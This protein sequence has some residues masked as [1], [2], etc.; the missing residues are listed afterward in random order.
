MGVVSWIMPLFVACSTFGALN[1]AIFASARLFFVGARN[2]HLPTSISLINIYNFTP[3]PSL[4]FLVRFCKNFIVLILNNFLNK[5]GYNIVHSLERKNLLNTCT[6]F[7]YHLIYYWIFNS[8]LTRLYINMFKCSFY[9]RFQTMI[10]YIYPWNFC[11][12]IIVQISLNKFK[13]CC[14]LRLS[15][16][17]I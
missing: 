14:W 1:G 10:T 9:L 8:Y 15:I 13:Y 11:I 4:I 2:G 12:K 17:A 16:Q 6:H 3:M 7:L 5:V